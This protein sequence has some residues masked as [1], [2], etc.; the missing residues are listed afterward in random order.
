M[1]SLQ[2]IQ[3]NIKEKEKMH[4]IIDYDGVI[5]ILN[6]SYGTEL[7]SPIYKR[8]FENF[9][10]KEFVD[11]TILI[12][13]KDK[14]FKP[15]SIYK[16]TNLNYADIKEFKETIETL[17]ESEFEPLYIGADKDI[18]KYFKNENR[19]VSS[20]TV[21][22]YL[23]M[24]QE[25][26]L[27]YKVSREDLAGKKILAVNEKYYIADH[28]IREAVYGNNG[29][30]IELILENIVYMELIRRGYDVTIGKAGT[31]EIDFIAKKNHQKIYIQVT[32]LLAS[33]Q[34][35]QREFGVYQSIQDNYPKYVVSMDEFDFSRDGIRHCNIRDLLLK[36]SYL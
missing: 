5:S 7:F 20:E 19:K 13:K 24:C 4:I 36:K 21:M 32:Y 33:E 30:D 35:I 18:V 16:N 9:A 22:N 27:I 11:F 6:S 34:T 10:K 31:K 8:I 29:R 26:F 1:N 25:A 23:K 14:R 15:K 3:Y 17:A 28:G 2:D 12:D